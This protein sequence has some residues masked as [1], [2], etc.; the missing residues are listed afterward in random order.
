VKDIFGKRTLN[1]LNIKGRSAVEGDLIL[2]KN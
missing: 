2:I 1:F